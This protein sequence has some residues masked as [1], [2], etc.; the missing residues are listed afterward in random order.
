MERR[1][2][3]WNAKWGR[4]ARRDI[5]IFE[6]AGR[7]LVEAREGGVDGTSRWF[8]V[9]DETSAFDLVRSLMSDSTDWRELSA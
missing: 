3:Y 6:D 9:T 7:W 5:M 8:D 2:H 4:I 1:R